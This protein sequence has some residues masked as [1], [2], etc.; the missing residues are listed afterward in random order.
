MQAKREGE[1]EI[2]IKEFLTRQ[3]I[4]SETR[5]QRGLR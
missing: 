2:E 1:R 5:E 4:K 3:F